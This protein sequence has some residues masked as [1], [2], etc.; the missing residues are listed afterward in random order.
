[1]IALN[2]RAKGKMTTHFIFNNEGKVV[3]TFQS[4]GSLMFLNL[5]EDSWHFECT[6]TIQLKTEVQELYRT[7]YCRNEVFFFSWSK[8]EDY[9]IN[10]IEYESDN[11]VKKQIKRGNELY[12]KL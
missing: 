11:I 10:I 8:R 6:N 7:F 2:C 3:K 12:R 4:C 9:C 1:M 5:S